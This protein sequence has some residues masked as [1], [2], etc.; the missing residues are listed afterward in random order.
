MAAPLESV[1][2]QKDLI[3]IPRN[4]NPGQKRGREEEIGTGTGAEKK[5]PGWPGENVFRMLVP[6]QKVG[7]IIGRKGEFVKKMCEETRSR[8]K[9]LDGLSGTPE[10]VVMVSAKEEPDATISPAMDGILKVHKRIIEGIDEVGR[11]Q[12]AAGG[13]TI[14]RLL[15]AGI[16]SG[17]LIGKQGAT[18]KS[19]QENSGVAAKVV[20]SEDIPYCALADDKVLEI[21][22]EPA[23]VHKALELVVSHL[24]KFLVDR[25]V[26]PM[27]EMNMSKTNQSQMEQNLSHQPWSHN[28]TSSLP[29]SGSGFGNNSKYTPTAPPH[30]NYYAPSDLPP[31]THSHHGLNM[32]GRDP[33]GGH[34][35]PNAAPAPVITQVSQRMQIPLSY[36]DAVIGTNGANISY[37]R[38]NS[39]AIITIEETRGVPGEMTVEIHG[40]ASQVQTAQQLIQN[41]M[42]GASGP[43]ADV[44]RA[45]GPPADVY[46]TSGPPADVYRASGPPADVY[47]ASGPPADVY[48][49]SGPPDVYNS[50]DSGYNSYSGHNTMYT[51]P[52]SNTGFAGHSAG[53]Y[54]SNYNNSYRY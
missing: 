30:D 19:I 34:S 22:G 33:L 41:F 40:T 46:R 36:A 45:S 14:T 10:R 27:Y 32:Y 24:R 37:C 26:L 31:E 11:T 39:G 44:Y 20:G 48:R 35:V 43:P 25:S 15:L 38:R 7:G 29:N 28:Q 2:E 4:A 50:I 51:S 13:P 17:S 53:G 12:Q 16:Q 54:E 52:R 23:N 1:Q 18:I 42:A 47:R 3:G 21:Q 8:I 49:A 6:S 9:I 5:W